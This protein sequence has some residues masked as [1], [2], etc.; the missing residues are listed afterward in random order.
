MQYNL[1]LDNLLRKL[2]PPVLKKYKFLRLIMLLG[3]PL[4]VVNDLFL[5]LVNKIKQEMIYNGQVLSLETILNTQ[6][7]Y[8]QPIYITDSDDELQNSYIYKTEESEPD[9]IWMY[10]TE[11]SKPDEYIYTNQEHIMISDFD[12]WVPLIHY[13]SIVA[14]GELPKFESIIKK[15]KI[16]GKKYSIKTY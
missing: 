2:C 9:E 11:E 4:Q 15:R 6:Y 14:A 7:P 16:A 10:Q 8:A 3:T 12:V 5:A 1:N 13:N